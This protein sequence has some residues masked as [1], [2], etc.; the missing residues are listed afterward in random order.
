VIGGE[1]RESVLGPYSITG[2]G[3]STVCMVQRYRV[4]D[5]RLL[6]LAAPCPPN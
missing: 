4:N 2:E 1:R 6:P 5:A 3:D